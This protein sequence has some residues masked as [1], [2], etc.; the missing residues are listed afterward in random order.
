MSRLEGQAVAH[1][2]HQARCQRR[3]LAETEPVPCQWLQP[4]LPSLH[5]WQSYR[6]LQVSD[7]LL[8]FCFVLLWC[9]FWRHQAQR[10][11]SLGVSAAGL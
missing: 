7:S 4:V 11:A 8:L 1:Q 9:T 3:T 10:L 2:G 6:G 5:D